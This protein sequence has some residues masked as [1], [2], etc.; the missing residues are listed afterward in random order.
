MQYTG[1]E[2]FAL[3]LRVLNFFFGQLRVLKMTPYLLAYFNLFIKCGRLC[4]K[5]CVDCL[6]IWWTLINASPSRQSKTLL[7]CPILTV[8]FP[9]LNSSRYL[10]KVSYT[11]DGMKSRDLLLHEACQYTKRWCSIPVIWLYLE[12]SSVVIFAAMHVWFKS[13]KSCL[14]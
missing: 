6:G 2:K 3:Y 8:S 7:R 5:E 11:V 13:E 4:I 1:E 14:V 9:D 10:K 12:Y